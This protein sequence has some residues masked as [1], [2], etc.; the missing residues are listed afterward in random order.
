MNIEAEIWYLVTL[1]AAFELSVNL[2]VIAKIAN[3]Q[4][5][6]RIYIIMYKFHIGD[7]PGNCGDMFADS[8]G[9]FQ[10]NAPFQVKVR[11]SLSNGQRQKG[12]APMNLNSLNCFS[13]MLLSG[14]ITNMRA[15]VRVRGEEPYQTE[16]QERFGLRKQP[17]FIAPGP[18]GVSLG[19]R[20]MKDGCFRR[21]RTTGQNRK[22]I[23]ACEARFQRFDLLRFQC[24]LLL[25]ES[26]TNI[27]ARRHTY[28]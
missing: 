11:F 10:V 18:S 1:F 24:F 25:L 17:S 20:A 16:W 6:T 28:L 8:S 7:H 4:F 26:E 3:A 14:E 9:K 13:T 22:N 21:L 19:P 2:K 5:Q 23:T 15:S 27:P 12:Q